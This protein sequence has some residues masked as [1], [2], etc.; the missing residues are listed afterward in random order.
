MPRTD[1][2]VPRILALLLP[3]LEAKD[4]DWRDQPHDRRQITLPATRDGKVNVR[5][6][7]RE[8]PGLRPSDEQH[9]FNKPDLSGAV[10]VIAK[11]QGLACIGSRVLEIIQDDAASARHAKDAT[12]NKQLATGLLEAEARIAALTRRIQQL[13]AELELRYETG[14]M[15]PPDMIGER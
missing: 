11:A 9:F 13:E 12:L 5:A 4:N 10:N 14:Q 3:Y 15:L 6:L 1:A 7:V 2:V 8:I